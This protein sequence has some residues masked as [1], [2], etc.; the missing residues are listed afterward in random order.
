MLIKCSVEFDPETGEGTITYP[1]GQLQ[2]LSSCSL[3][4]E[5]PAVE[6]IEA[7]DAAMDGM[8][9]FKPGPNVTVTLSGIVPLAAEKVRTMPSNV[10]PIDPKVIAR[11][12]RRAR[13]NNSE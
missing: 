7:E 4:I 6:D 2:R 12:K 9:R 8:A 5:R 3:T 1:G 13:K 11:A 10:Q